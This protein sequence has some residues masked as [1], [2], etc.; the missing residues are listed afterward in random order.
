MTNVDVNSDL[1]EK[2]VKAV[3]KNN[4][5][6]ASINQFVN[7]AVQEKLDSLNGGAT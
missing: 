1:Y 7:Q 3:N 2:I 6:F 5:R 4:I